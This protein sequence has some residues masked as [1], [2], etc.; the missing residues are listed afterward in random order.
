MKLGNGTIA[1]LLGGLTAVLLT[2]T[3]PRIGLTWDEPAYIAG[4]DAIAGWFG[5]LVRHPV[6]AF[7]SETIARY[8]AVNHEHPP[9]SK[10]WT[11]LVWLAAAP[12]FDDLTAHR[13]GAILLVAFLVAWLYL[14][15]APAY[16]QTAGLFAAAAL[17]SMPRFFFHAHLVALDVPV[18]VGAFAVAF[19]FWKTVDRQEWWWGV[20]LGV[21][22][23]LAVATKLNGVFIPLALVIWGLVFRRRWAM[24]ARL[25]LMGVSAVLTFF[26]VW[27]WLYHETWE[28]VRE[29]VLFHLHHYRI[30]QW[31]FGEFYLPPPWHFPLVMLWAV[32]PLT[33]LLLALAGMAR[34]GKGRQDGGLA[35]LLAI[36]A[37]VSL[38]PFLSGKV[39]L[40]NNDRLFMPVYP[41]LAAL[42]GIGCGW[43]LA[44][45]RRLAERLRRPW[46][47]VPASAVL[48]ALLLAPQAVA[49]ARLYPYLLS[50]YSETVG[51]LPGATR[52]GLETTYWCE[53]YADALPA[54]NAQAKP[55]D[56]IWVEAKS[57]DVLIY[58]QIH[59]RLR[60][61]VRVMRATYGDTGTAPST[62]SSASPW[63]QRP[64]PG[65]LRPRRAAAAGA[66]TGH[67]SRSAPL[68]RPTTRWN[69][70]TV[71][72]V[73]GPDA[74]QPVPGKFADADWYIFQYRQ[75]QYG[76][77][78]ENDLPRLVFNGRTPVYEVRVHGVPLMGLYGSLK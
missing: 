21:V 46:L 53:T 76:P 37:F 62:S 3:A 45:L 40:Y 78:A 69:P 59:G 7:Q 15:V 55:G 26:L 2:A 52:M 49:M 65:G 39:L 77:D 74:P 13:L 51:G 57:F 36:N 31:Y 66:T 56:L 48:L 63:R 32:L 60:A 8:W 30:G 6:Q 19:L 14:L 75:S 42:A 71:R 24:L 61:D 54:I 20:V 47:T 12:V 41:F 33:V 38:A 25:L 5:S 68:V 9:V 67:G 27:P 16:G 23:G 29:Y 1:L 22:W 10:I 28:R 72:S 73:F 43:V 70:T 18:A 34:A 58:Y 50:Y 44:G 11:G 64:P 17:L 35:W 4:A